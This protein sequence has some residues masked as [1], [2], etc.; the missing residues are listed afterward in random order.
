MKKIGG[1]GEMSFL[2][3]GFV[4]FMLIIIVMNYL[5]PDKLRKYGLFVG[6]LFFYYVNASEFILLLIPICLITYLFGLIISKWRKPYIYIIGMISILSFLICFKYS[7][8][9]IVPIGI[10]FMIFQAISYLGDVYN[11]KLD[12]EKNFVIVAL[13]VC[14]F[15][16]ISAGPIQ[17]ARNFI[18]QLKTKVE[19]NYEHI[20]HGILLFVFGGLQKFY[21]S[22][23]LEVI[24]QSMME[25]ISDYEGFHYWFFAA[26]YAIYIYSNFNAYSDMAIGVAEILGIHF[27]PNFKRPYLATSI[28]E[29]WQRWHI[30]LNSWFVEYVYI[31]LGGSRKGK[32]RYYINV[33]IVFF[34]S[35]L[36]HGA[37]LHF[38]IWGLL[39]AFYQ[40]IGDATYKLRKKICDKL[41]VSENTPC[42]LLV[43]R[44]FVFYL[45][46][47][48][49]IFFAIKETKLAFDIVKSMLFP[50]ILTL[51][52][53]VIGRQ[54]ES[55]ASAIWI[56]LIILLFAYIQIKR[57]K[58]SVS[59]LIAK[60]PG[61][62][63]NVIYVT[64][65]V[66]LVFG[67]VGTYTGYGA[68]GFI[69]ENF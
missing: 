61:L 38:I 55:L 29:F 34:L 13:Q 9:L 31:P 23:K 1:Y 48:S 57:E 60:E 17:K 49:W 18:P 6:S 2:S 11:Q 45:I 7:D 40:I 47:I 32:V 5:L 37:G 54:F 8:G 52:D 35:G 62:I 21:L 44:I 24:I 36:W 10:S 3:I 22:D 41:G 42:V 26:I 27:S 46:S 67:F 53:E 66:F 4:G 59:L 64:M 50:S 14:F 30:S 43:K 65:F 25:N 20:R 39:N 19:V 28:K 16:N 51:Y 63:R 68:G 33:V 12:V 15:A 69:Y 58:E 56:I